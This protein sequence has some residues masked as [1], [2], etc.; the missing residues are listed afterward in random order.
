MKKLFSHH[1]P[2]VIYLVLFSLLFSLKIIEYPSPFF[3]WDESIYAQVGREMI[4]SKSYFIPLW[5]GEE[6]LDKPPLVPL[7]YGVVMTLTPFI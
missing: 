4:E 7:F 5:Q 3:D 2:L 6:W 1:Y